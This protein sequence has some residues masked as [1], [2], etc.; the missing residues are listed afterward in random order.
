MSASGIIVLVGFC[1]GG[2]VFVLWPFIGARLSK[3]DVGAV[4]EPSASTIP[5]LVQLQ[6]VHET[7]LK[8]VRDLDFDYQMGKLDDEDY[9]AEREALMVRG[10][11]VLEQL[12]SQAIETSETIEAAVRARRDV[13]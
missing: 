3:D 9:R 13:S 7:L 12:D 2:A 1:V 5:R 4:A 6:T 8:A 10:M 11:E